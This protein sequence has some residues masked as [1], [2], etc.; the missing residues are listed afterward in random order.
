MNLQILFALKFGPQGGDQCYKM[1]PALTTNREAFAVALISRTVRGVVPTFPSP[2][3]GRSP[4]SACSPRGHAA[5]PA[6]PPYLRRCCRRRSRTP[7]RGTRTGA[8]STRPARSRDRCRPRSRTGRGRGTERPL[9]A[10]RAP[11]TG[12]PTRPGTACTRRP[13]RFC[14]GDKPQQGHG[15]AQTLP[16]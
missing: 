5:G 12:A 15:Q 16:L 6:P 1:T 7:T 11:G 2:G 9:G 8:R 13:A 14:R 10:A 3:S 4:G